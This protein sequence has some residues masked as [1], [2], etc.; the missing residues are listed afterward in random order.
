[1]NDCGVIVPPAKNK[2]Q[3]EQNK[4]VAGKYKTQYIIN[5][6]ANRPKK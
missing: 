5:I 2:Y 6:K 4:E 1:M 3:N